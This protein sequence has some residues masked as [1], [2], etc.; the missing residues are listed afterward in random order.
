M[1]RN[2]VAQEFEHLVQVGITEAN[3]REV[4]SGSSKEMVA[5]AQRWP[6]ANA[7]QSA[8]VKV[9]PEKIAAASGGVARY[10]GELLRSAEYLNMETV[11]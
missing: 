11:E 2:S 3:P 8:R 4:K 7:N 5:F 10:T 6:T 1:F 9:L